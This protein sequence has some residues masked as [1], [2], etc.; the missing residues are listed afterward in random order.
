MG[1]ALDRAFWQAIATWPPLNHDE[2]QEHLHGDA[3][4]TWLDR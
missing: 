3:T 4:K 2:K 1:A